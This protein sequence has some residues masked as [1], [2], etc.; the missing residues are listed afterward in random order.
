MGKE[1]VEKQFNKEAKEGWRFAAGAARVTVERAS[2][3]DQQ[4]T[5]GGVFVAVGSNLGAVAGEKEESH[6]HGE[7]QWR[8][9]YLHGVL[10]ALGRMDAEK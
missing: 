8:I 2:S 4:H 6:K 5:S 3:E 10:L 9:A 7:C 1:E